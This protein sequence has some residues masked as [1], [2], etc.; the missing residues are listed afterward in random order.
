MGQYYKVC[1]IDK[2]EFINCYRL[3]EGAKL[4]EQ[5]F[6]GSLVASALM[7]LLADGN[8]RGMG[9][10]HSDSPIVGSWAGDRIVVAGD[11]ADNMRYVEYPRA[12]DPPG[13]KHIDRDGCIYDV[14]EQWKDISEQI[15]SAMTEDFYLCKVLMQRERWDGTNEMVVKRRPIYRDRHSSKTR[16]YPNDDPR[17]ISDERTCDRFE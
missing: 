16:F 6:P 12:D 17:R 4:M 3:G 14:A 11:Y 2:K 15:V 13:Q 7:I 5:G 1:N 8:G 10:L 9:D